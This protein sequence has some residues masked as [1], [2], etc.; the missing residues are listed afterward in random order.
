[1]RPPTPLPAAL[2]E[3]VFT[4]RGAEALGVPPKRLRARD[5]LRVG[6]GLYRWIGSTPDVGQPDDAGFPLRPAGHGSSGRPGPPDP[7]WLRMLRQIQDEYTDSWLSHTTA[8]RLHGLQLPGW[9]GDESV[10][11]LSR[12]QIST[13]TRR[14]PQLRSHAV[15]VGPGE[16]VD[17]AG[18]RVSRPGRVFFDLMG[19]LPEREL[20]AL[21]DQLVRRPHAEL[22]GRDE[23][24]ETPSSLA[25]LVA[26]HRRIKGIVKGRRALDQV[27][28]GADSRPETLLRLAILDAG[29]PEPQL[30]VRPRPDSP[31]SGDLGYEDRLIVLQY[32]GAGHFSAAQQ[33]SDQR[34]NFAFVQD[35]WTVLPVNVEDLRDGFRRV[36][37]RLLLAFDG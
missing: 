5:V 34:R 21:G 12:P 1:M 35:G 20:V 11:H 18:L 4:R 23:P 3:G 2:R 27:R 26:A 36:V 22:E 24:W 32:E 31:W 19:T 29:L 7:A 9:A 13:T 16:V 30:Q 10:V 17:V 28:I 6:R 33:A 25:A 14:S 37:A 15:V 8:A